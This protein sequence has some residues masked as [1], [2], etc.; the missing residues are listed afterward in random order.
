MYD[1]SCV[2]CTHIASG[3]QC[4]LVY[5]Y[6]VLTCIAIGVHFVLIHMHVQ[7]TCRGLLGLDTNG[8]EVRG[9]G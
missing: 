7:V 6:S 1:C 8:L 4:V 9:D 2:K 5:K 3:A